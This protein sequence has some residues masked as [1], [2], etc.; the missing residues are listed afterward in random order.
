VLPRPRIAQVIEAV[1][2]LEDRDT[3]AL[4]SLVVTD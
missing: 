4:I 3:R 1:A 2:A